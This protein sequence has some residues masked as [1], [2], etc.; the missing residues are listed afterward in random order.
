MYKD[1]SGSCTVMVKINN[2]T[3]QINEYDKNVA[4][5]MEL[6]SVNYVTNTTTHR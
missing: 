6:S 4:K 2:L 1:N 3:F 5:E